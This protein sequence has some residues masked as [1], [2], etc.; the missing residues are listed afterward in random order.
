MQLLRGEVDRFRGLV[1]HI[2][3]G[4]SAYRQRNCE[5]GCCEIIVVRICISSHNFYVVGVYRNPDLSDKIFYCFTTMAKVQILDIKAS[6]LLVGD[7]NAPHNE[8]V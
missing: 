1:A 6:F 4:F 2:R 7:V 3:D 8:W 5:C